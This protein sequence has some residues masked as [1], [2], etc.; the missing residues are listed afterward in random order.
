MSALS[1]GTDDR[2]GSTVFYISI[3]GKG[4]YRSTDRGATWAPFV[5][6][7]K[8]PGVRYITRYSATSNTA[9]DNLVYWAATVAGPYISKDGGSSWT[10]GGAGLPMGVAVNVAIDST[11]V[12]YAAARWNRL[13]QVAQLAASQPNFDA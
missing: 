9:S 7:D 8:L 12:A 11:G 5:G 6:T 3:D 4:I 2:T 10:K 1:S 13:E